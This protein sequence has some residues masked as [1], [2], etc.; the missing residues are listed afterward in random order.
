MHS[1]SV[2]ANRWLGLCPKAPVVRTVQADLDDPAEPIHAGSPDGGTGGLGSIRRGVGAARSGMKTLLHNP[3]LF[4]FPLLA[5][6]VL[7]GNIIGQTAFWYIEYNLHVPLDWIAWQFFI[8]FATVFCLVF[9][10]AGLFLSIPS[11][12]EGSVSFSEGLAGAKKYLKAILLW[13]MVLALAGMLL[14]WL[15]FTFPSVLWWPRELWAYNI[16]GQFDSFLFSTLSQF[17]FNPTLR[18][19][20]FTEFP[21]YGG[22][23]VLLWIYHGLRDA[24][25]FLAINLLLLLLTLFVVPFIVLGKKTLR[26]AALGSFALMKRTWVELAACAVFLGA[27]V[28][29]VFLAYLLVGAAYGTLAP[30]EI[31]NYRP[32]VTWIALALLYDLALFSVAFVVATVGGIAALDLYTSAKIRQLPGSTEPEPPA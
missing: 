29:C 23:S 30:L 4:W 22:R 8:E 11:K 27:L 6:L 7:A 12:K 32:T 10:L 16:F 9:L 20:L 25:I 1:I 5:G 3:Q 14:D 13:S 17:P 18:W 2:I 26:E 28:S 21:G 31:V 24:L 15:F 19:D